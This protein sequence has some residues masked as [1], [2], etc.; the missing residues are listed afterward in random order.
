MEPGNLI[1]VQNLSKVFTTRDGLF[2]KHLV[3]AVDGV[4]FSLR[5]GETLALVGESGS[6][7][8]TVG[9]MMLGLLD[10]SSGQVLYKGKPVSNLAGQ[11][12]KE[13]R[14]NV[15]AVFQDPSLSLNPRMTVGAI[16]SEP[17]R[18]FFK[19]GDYRQKVVNLLEQVG[20]AGE[21]YSRY[22][23]QCSG[24]Q[25]QR[26][27][28]ARALAVRPKVIV[29]DEPLSALDITVQTKIIALL[30]E[31]KGLYGI[32]YLFISHDLRAVRAIADRIIVMYRGKIVETADTGEFMSA[33][34]HFHSKALLAAM[35]RLKI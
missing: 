18:N 26:I 27:A 19:T 4:S 20:L 22:P 7:K 10:P 28:I 5:Q 35:P 21:F 16:I 11:A 3:T 23:H 17:L 13:F 24:G 33:P 1:Q 29:L 31:L 34:G 14:Q 15:Q 12:A 8:T 6:G 32:T 2:R 9:R 25:K 30:N